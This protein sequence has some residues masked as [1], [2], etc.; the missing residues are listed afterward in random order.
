MQQKADVAMTYMSFIHG[1]HE[2]L[3]FS[4]PF[5]EEQWNIMMSRP[6]ETTDGDG[7]VAPFQS[8]VL[9]LNNDKE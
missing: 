3:D 8:E 1:R 2:Y 6:R 9:S 5:G 7:L 4:R